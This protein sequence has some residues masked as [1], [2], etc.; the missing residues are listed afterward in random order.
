MK[1][2]GFIIFLVLIFLY[3]LLGFINYQINLPL[4]TSARVIDTRFYDYAGITHIQ[5]QLSTGSG[6]INEI[7][8]A[9]YKAQCS[10]LIV[11]DLNVLDDLSAF[12]GY[13]ND[14][15]VIAGSKFSFLG[16]HLLVYNHKDPWPFKGLGQAQIYFNDLLQTSSAKKPILVAAHPFLSKHSWDKLTYAGLSGMEVLNIDKLWQSELQYHK[17]RIFW[18][19]IMF[20]FN[21]DLSYLRL[22]SE[23]VNEITAWDDA[24]SKKQF[25]GWAGS[26]AKAKAIPFPDKVFKF[27]SYRQ[28]FRLI[29]NH[30]LLKSEL[31]GKFEDDKE[32]ILTA[33]QQGHFYFS[34]DIL[35]DPKGF[36]FIAKDGNKEFLMGDVIK[37]QPGQPIRLVAD[38]GRKLEIPHEIILL[39]DGSPVA[40]STGKSVTYNATQ[41][42]SYRVVVRLKPSLPLP[43]TGREFSWIFSNSI[44]ID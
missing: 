37:Y 17:W 15:L 8:N 39:K 31:T 11:T 7:S 25:Y 43:D 20:P 30:V 27:P 1:K 35:G 28:S 22:F 21:P 2:L 13:K 40:T 6:T 18:T 12:E 16:G 24:L 9:A 36:Y 19:L 41:R 42:G 26:G 14:V 33:L 5:T 23:P 34:L 44:R 32:K 38:L 10:F 4:I 29:K 3:T